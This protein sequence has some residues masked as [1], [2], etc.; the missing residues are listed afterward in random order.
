MA[1]TTFMR[2]VYNIAL[3]KGA[4]A[5]LFLAVVA[6]TL[7]HPVSLGVS[8]LDLAGVPLFVWLARRWPR[9][10]A[11]AL[12]AETALALT[13]RQFVQGYV[14]GINWPIYIVIP[15]IAAYL[16]RDARAAAWGAGLTALI[17]LPVMLVATLTLPAGMRPADVWTLLV[18]VLGLMLGAALLVG[19][20]LR[21]STGGEKR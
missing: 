14:N 4:L 6:F 9:F 5:A 15:L 8:V 19:D 13:P 16:L 12:V 21:S 3:V 20:M 11:Y 18:F 2:R 1:D 7:P 10:A 17:A